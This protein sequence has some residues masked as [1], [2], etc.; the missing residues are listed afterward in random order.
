[1]DY[2]KKNLILHEHLRK[3]SGMLLVEYGVVHPLF[4]KRERNKIALLLFFQIDSCA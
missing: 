1:L 2:Q 4:N 3:K